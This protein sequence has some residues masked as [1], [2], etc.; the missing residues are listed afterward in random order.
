M[1]QSICYPS[2]VLLFDSNCFNSC[3]S[4]ERTTL[5]KHIYESSNGSFLSNEFESSDYDDLDDDLDSSDSC[6]YE[7]E[8]TNSEIKEKDEF[9]FD[10]IKNDSFSFIQFDSKQK[11]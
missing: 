10:S 5:P 4:L 8:L 3:S 1:F 2:S 11:Q 7:N 9:S 6:E